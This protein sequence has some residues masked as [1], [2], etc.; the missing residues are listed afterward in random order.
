[1]MSDTVNK[2]R[3]Q[4]AQKVGHHSMKTEEMIAGLQVVNDAKGFSLQFLFFLHQK[5]GDNSGKLA[6]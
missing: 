6:G 5:V 4:Y 1:M 2:W 3:L